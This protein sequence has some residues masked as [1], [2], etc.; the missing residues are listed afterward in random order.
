MSLRRRRATTRLYRHCH[1]NDLPVMLLWRRV[2]Y[3]V[4]EE[5]TDTGSMH[6]EKVL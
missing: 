3:T 4:T 6:M 2:G 5:H 1:Y